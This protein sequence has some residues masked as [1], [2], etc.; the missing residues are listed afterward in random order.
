MG[1]TLG[2]NTKAQEPIDLT[3]SEQRTPQQQRNGASD[4]CRQSSSHQMR[5]SR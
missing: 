2:D 5:F 1:N 4:G 3:L